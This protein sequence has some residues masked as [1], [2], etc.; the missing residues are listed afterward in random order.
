MSDYQPGD[1]S[2]AYHPSIGQPTVEDLQ[3]E[4]ERDA[5]RFGL[6][7]DVALAILKRGG[8]LAQAAAFRDARTL[9]EMTEARRRLAEW[10]DSERK[11]KAA[12]AGFRHD[13]A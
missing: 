8:S 5:K 13:P 6:E 11:R 4:V 1:N 3:A 2:P 10:E 7:P 12:E 9:D